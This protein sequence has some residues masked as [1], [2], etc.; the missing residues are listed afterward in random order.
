MGDLGAAVVIVVLAW[1]ASTGVL[2]RVIWSP[3]RIVRPAFVI[4]S[5]LALAGAYA[6]VRTA[7]L[8]TTTGAYVGF[9]SALAL[10]AWH[11]LAFLLGVISGPRKQP[12]R[13]ELR[14]LA[15]FVEATSTIIHHEIALAATVAALVIMTW[16]APNQVATSTFT[17]LWLMRLSAKLNL[18]F[19]ARS[20]TEEFVPPRLR[21]LTTY[22]RRSRFNPLIVVSLAAGAFGLHLLVAASLAAE[23]SSFAAL[24]HTLVATMVALGVLE[25][26]FLAVP[27][28]D[29]RLWRWLVRT[30]TPRVGPD[31]TRAAESSPPVL[32]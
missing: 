29:A 12:C 9:A 20:I 8:T 16:G 32:G 5:V 1:W 26:A 21:Y 15:R 24:A 23:P 7:T 6:A 31:A 30:R 11:E 25:H 4:T 22:F 28:D 2:L 14:G 19:G 18:F 27:L 13:P 17:V 10:W 3:A